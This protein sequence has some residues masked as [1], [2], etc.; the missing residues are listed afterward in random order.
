M[1]SEFISLN[2]MNI[3]AKYYDKYHKIP[4]YLEIKQIFENL[5]SEKALK[6]QENWKDKNEKPK[7]EKGIYFK[8]RRNFFR[9]DH[10]F[11]SQFDKKPSDSFTFYTDFS[12]E[13]NKYQNLFT[14]NNLSVDRFSFA[15]DFAA[16]FYDLLQLRLHIFPNRLVV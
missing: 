16:D 10:D 15:R 7:R 6:D 14:Q 3:K 9:Y 11:L 12:T 13:T 2:L 8:K 1:P 4:E 5:L